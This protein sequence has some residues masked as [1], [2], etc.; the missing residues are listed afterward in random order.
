M[1]YKKF[2]VEATSNGTLFIVSVKGWFGIWKTGFIYTSY[3]R[4][5]YS[6]KED[7][8]QAIQGYKDRFTEV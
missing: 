6:S 7:A 3:F 5:R 8:L 4:P 2:K 1:N